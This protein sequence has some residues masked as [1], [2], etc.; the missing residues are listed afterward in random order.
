[1]SS[2]TRVD[3][4]VGIDLGTTNSEIAWLA[5]NERDL[6]IY[7]DKFGRK[8]VPSAVGW[9][10]RTKE[11]VVG[12]AARNL[13]SAGAPLVESIKRSM[14]Q[15]ALVSL[16]DASFLRPRF[17]PRFSRNSQHACVSTCTRRWVVR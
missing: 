15:T 2:R 9:N 8:T 17:R 13:R 1:M 12:H 14:G 4:A 7:A 16:G 11:Y 10:N 5:P 3:R 6:L